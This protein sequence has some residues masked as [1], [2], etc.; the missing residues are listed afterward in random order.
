[1]VYKGWDSSR[2]WL[3]DRRKEKEWAYKYKKNYIRKLR[4]GLKKDGIVTKE[5]IEVSFSEGF[6]K[7]AQG[8]ADSSE[9]EVADPF[10]KLSCFN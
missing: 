2:L 4:G 1:M 10:E 3:E 7:P 8:T 5:I 9:G 6:Q